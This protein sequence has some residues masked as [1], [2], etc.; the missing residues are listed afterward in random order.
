MVGNEQATLNEMLE[1]PIVCLVMACD[2]VTRADV[3]SLFRNL[4]RMRR[5]D[6][7][8]YRLSTASRGAEQGPTAA[9]NWRGGAA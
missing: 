1:D 6:G 7:A 9:Q 5:D 4:R 2:G 3:E 8:I